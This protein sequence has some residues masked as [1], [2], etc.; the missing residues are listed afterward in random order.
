M[1]YL[2]LQTYI[3]WFLAGSDDATAGTCGVTCGVT[4]FRTGKG[5]LNSGFTERGREI[6]MRE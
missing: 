6:A 5:E 3:K 2:F 4:P 1:F